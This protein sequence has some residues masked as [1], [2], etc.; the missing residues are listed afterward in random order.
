MNCKESS[1][2][3]SIDNMNLLV[4]ND[5]QMDGFLKLQI[6]IHPLDILKMGRLNVKIHSLKFNK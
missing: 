6:L 5:R 4:Y 1:G 2:S 3:N